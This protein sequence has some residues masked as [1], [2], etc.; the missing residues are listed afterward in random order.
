MGFSSLVVQAL[1]TRNDVAW[2]AVARVHGSA[3]A[4]DHMR[5]PAASAQEHG[6]H[7]IHRDTGMIRG[8][9]R[10]VFDAVHPEV[11]AGVDPKAVSKVRSRQAVTK[12]DG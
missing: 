5:D 6:R 3:D 4:I 10:I 2:A 8:Y 12:Y 11:K 9:H 7:I 1:R